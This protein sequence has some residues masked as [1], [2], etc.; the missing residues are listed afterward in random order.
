MSP[1]PPELPFPLLGLDAMVFIYHFDQEPLFGPLASDLLAA[2]EERRRCQLVTSTVALLELL[3]GPKRRGR[4]ELCEEYRSFLQSL[5]SLAV[6]P[7][8]QEVAELG[9]GLRARYNIATPDSIHVATA[10][11]SDADAFVSE[12]GRL[13]RIVE[14]P[15]LSLA[16]ALGRVGELGSGEVHEPPAHYGAR[17]ARRRSLRAG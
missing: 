12:D 5:S 16:E 9:A 6:E 10:L 7:V 14:I 4:E 8:T 11:A 3:V 2:A 17:R 13:K 15:V 1:A